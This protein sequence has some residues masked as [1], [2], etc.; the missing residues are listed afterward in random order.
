MCHGQQ[1]KHRIGRTAHRNIQRHGIEEC[2]TG[3]YAA[4]KY[5]FVTFFIIF[6]C[7][8]H[9]QFGSIFK[10]F[11]TIFV[12]SHDCAVSRKSQADSFIQ[13]VHRVCRKHSGTTSAGRTGILF[14]IRYFLIAYTVVRRF[15][16]GIDQVQMLTV[17]LSGFHRSTGYKYGRDIQAHGSHQ[18][19]WGNLIAVADTYHC[20]RLVRIDHIFYAVRYDI[21]GRKRVKHSVMSHSDTVINSNR[22]KF[23]SEASQLLNFRLHQLPDFMQVHVSRNKLCKRIDDSD[24][25]FSH[26]IFLHAVGCP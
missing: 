22:I 26:L 5:T 11:R 15:N 17:P 13:T 24:N 25:G 18:H 19:P 9:N 23:R 10:Q 4:R 20:I 3:S 16:H 8:F 14:D 1:V 7:I 2:L 12:R 6:H 21:T